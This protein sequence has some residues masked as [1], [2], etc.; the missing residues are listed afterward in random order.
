MRYPPSMLSTVPGGA[1]EVQSQA[2]LT[3]PS[4]KPESPPGLCR[5]QLHLLFEDQQ[6]PQNAV[7]LT[8]PSGPVLS[9]WKDWTLTLPQ[10]LGQPLPI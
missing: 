9:L 4:A 2:L 3:R 7:D 8:W 6:G 5:A 1:A 10:V